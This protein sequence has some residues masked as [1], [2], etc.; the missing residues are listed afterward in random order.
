MSGSSHTLKLIIP[1]VNHVPF[2]NDGKINRYPIAILEPW[3]L[4]YGLFGPEETIDGGINRHIIKISV[5]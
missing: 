4:L 2:L 1:D 5:C 3:M